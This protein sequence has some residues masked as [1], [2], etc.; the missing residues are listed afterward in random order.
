MRV[1]VSTI[2]FCFVETPTDGVDRI[3][4]PPAFMDVCV[5]AL[6]RLSGPKV[7]EFGVFPIRSG[8][9]RLRDSADRVGFLVRRVS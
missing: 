6:S 3:V 8:R 1:V 9:K 7:S 4:S 2:Y 5:D